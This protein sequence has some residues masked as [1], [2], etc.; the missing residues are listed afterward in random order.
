M[1]DTTG[2]MIYQYKTFSHDVWVA[3]SYDEKL[4]YR[5]LPVVFVNSLTNEQLLYNCLFWE[6]TGDITL[7]NTHQEGYIHIYNS[8]NGLRELNKRNNVESLLLNKL[9]EIT[10]SDI[11][12]DCW[13]KI[14]I[15]EMICAQ[16]NIINQYNETDTFLALQKW[17]YIFDEITNN[18]NLG[19]YDYSPSIRALA[20]ILL[21]ANYNDFRPF[22]ESAKFQN[23]INGT[24]EIDDEI[25]SNVIDCA[26]NYYKLLNHK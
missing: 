3:M 9:Q 25:I 21:K 18:K 5:Q 20:N 19:Y 12:I 23:Y 4:S 10:P 11:T 13:L 17:I 15:T 7:F 26:K 24:I 16:E 8:F 22:S 6:L 14:L 2:K 1:N